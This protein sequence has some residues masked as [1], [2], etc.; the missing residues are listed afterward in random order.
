MM[1]LLLL[2]PCLALLRLSAADLQVDPVR[3]DDAADGRSAPVRTLARAIRLAAPGDTIHLQPGVVYSDSA[4]FANKHGEPGR[5]ITLDGHGAILDGS[6]P[7][8]AAEWEAL[9]GGLFRKSDLVPSLNDAML[10]RWFFLWDGRMNTMGRTS[11]GPKAAFKKPTELQ[12]GEWTHA[13]GAFYLRLAEGA[14]LDAANI[15]Y[16][17]RANAVSQ[18]GKGSHLV[19]RNVTGRHV[20]N[21][22]FNVHGSQRALVFENI[23]AIECGDDGFSAHEDAECRIDGFVSMGNSTGL[24]DTVSSVTHYRNV[25]IR[26]CQ[27]Y[28]VFFI[29]DSPHSMENVIVESTA[30]RALEI[31]RH[32][33]RPQNGVGEV[34]LKNVL[35]RRVAPTPGVAHVGAGV[36]LRMENCTLEGVQFTAAAGGETET[37]RSVFRGQSRLEIREGARW[38]GQGNRYDLLELVVGARR[39]GAADFVS[40][41]QAVQGEVGSAWGKGEGAGAD[42]SWHDKKSP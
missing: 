42:S 14:D 27:G 16:P 19:I 18:A 2:L 22:G 25:Y 20:Y 11:K 36:R 15:R 28:D 35:I 32:N 23:A 13:D 39:F 17:A 12:P 26:D 38:A 34:V 37:R 9:G 24:C 7:V 40:F 1:R 29:G 8:R 33:D 3:G 30:A 31:A 5:P 21:D 10:G 41:Q 6:E 4:V